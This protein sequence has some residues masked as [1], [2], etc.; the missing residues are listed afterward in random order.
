MIQVYEYYISH[1]LAKAFESLFC[2]VTCLPGCFSLYRIRTADKGRPI[3]ISSRIIDEYSEPNVD[4][5]HKKNLLSLGEDRFLTTHMMRHFPTYRMK[6]MHNLC[7]LVFLPEFCGFCCFSMRF[8]VFIDL[9]G[10]IILPATTLVYLIIIVAT[11]QAPIPIISLILIGAVY[12]LQA[13]IFILKREFMLVGWMVIYLLSYPI[14][15]FFLPVYSFWSMDDFSWGNTRLVIGEGNSKKVMIADDE[16]F[17]D[18]MIPLKKFSEY[19]AEAWETG[20]ASQSGDF[21]HN[22]NVTFN[23]SSNPNMRLGPNQP[24]NVSMSQYGGAPPALPQQQCGTP[25]M[26]FL[27]MGAGPGSVHGSEYGGVPQVGFPNTASM[28][29]MGMAMDPRNTV[30]SNLNMFGGGGSG[31][32]SGAPPSAMPNMNMG[33]QQMSTFSMATSFS[34]FVSPS[35]STDPTDEELLG[36]LRHYLSTQDLMTV[37][38]KTAREAVMARFPNADLTSRKDFLNQSI[39]SILSES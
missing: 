26:P 23:N 38:K 31:S 10:T 37:T 9:L 36:V 28:Y 35:Q 3:I 20:S 7:E 22:T 21:Y 34:P 32:F 11:G 30:M 14:Y 4:T 1:H 33:Q 12:G 6:F 19:K 13:L 5:L 18:S 2:S 27:P 29:G 25:Q 24:S 8:I 16:K 17:N 15:S 39:D